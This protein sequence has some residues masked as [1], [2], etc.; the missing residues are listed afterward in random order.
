MRCGSTTAS[1]QLGTI[2][3]P[4]L[5]VIAILIMLV[6]NVVVICAYPNSIY[7]IVCFTS[8][9]VDQDWQITVLRKT[10]NQ[11]RNKLRR[12]AIYSDRFQKF[13]GS[14]LFEKVCQACNR[15]TTA[16]MRF[17]FARN[18]N[19]CR[20]TQFFKLRFRNEL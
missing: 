9:C 7:T 20:H 4:R 16:H 17:V 12:S 15:L 3:D 8:V 19:P 11:F 5:S 6:F 13:W 1:N 10:F 18:S 2:F 14:N